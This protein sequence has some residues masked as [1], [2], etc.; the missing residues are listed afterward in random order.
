MQANLLPASGHSIRQLEPFEANAFY[1]VHRQE[2]A[3]V[4]VLL[5]RDGWV[6]ID[7]GR[8]RLTSEDECNRIGIRVL[9]L[10]TS[11][12]LDRQPQVIGVMLVAADF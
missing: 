5:K 11:E 6:K 9:K 1:V 7:R 3:P 12:R 8:R 2:N 4:C 10:P